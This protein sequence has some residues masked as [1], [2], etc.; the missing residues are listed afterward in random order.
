MGEIEAQAGRPEEAA[1]AFRRTIELDPTRALV[2]Y[3]LGEV[4]REQG[5]KQLAVYAFEQAARRAGAAGTLRARSDWRV[6]TLTFPL[7]TESGLTGATRSGKDELGV[8]VERYPE[9]ARKL[10][11]WGRLGPRYVKHAKDMR[12]RWLAPGESTGEEKKV[13]VDGSMITSTFEVPAP[14]AKAGSWTLEIRFEGDTLLK[15]SV[16]VGG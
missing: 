10:T 1:E 6:I 8:L 15:R 13:S 3:R 9:G 16:P 11:W 5:D 14:G 7:V 12:A 4:T 2:F